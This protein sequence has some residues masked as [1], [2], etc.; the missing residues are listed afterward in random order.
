MPGT[1]TNPLF[2]AVPGLAATLAAARWWWQGT[3][4]VWTKLDFQVYVQDADLGWRRTDASFAWLGLDVVF[5]LGALT[6]ATALAFRLLGKWE[7]PWTPRAVFATK[8]VALAAMAVPLY[9]FASGS[10]PPG[11]AESRPL[12]TVAVSS[13]GIRASVDGLPAGRYAV[14][15]SRQSAIVA[16]LVA[17]G[18]VFDARFA[19]GLEGYWEATPADLTRPMAARVSVRAASIDTGIELRNEHALEELRPKE[20]PAIEFHLD[21]VKSTERARDGVAFAASGSAV[22]GGRTHVVD[23]TGTLQPVGDALAAKLELSEG[24]HVLLQA[25]FSLNLK[26]TIVGND[27]TFDVDDVPISATLV[28]KHVETKT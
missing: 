15:P 26:E 8:A 24:V 5:L 2:A 25:T 17:G 7:R 10:P 9:A 6:L 28:L 1:K 16:K 14:V 18:E 13:G 12:L 20:Y 27:G 23:I 21:S 3:G 11:A 4:N 22:L 19:G